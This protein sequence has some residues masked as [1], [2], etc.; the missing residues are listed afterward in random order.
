MVVWSF[1]DYLGIILRITLQCLL[2]ICSTSH[3]PHPQRWSS[4]VGHDLDAP[5]GRIAHRTAELHPQP[6]SRDQQ[7]FPAYFGVRFMMFH[8]RHLGRTQLHL[9]AI[10]LG[11][12]S[13][14]KNMDIGHH[15]RFGQIKIMYVCIFKTIQYILIHLYIYIYIY[16]HTTI[17]VFMIYAIP[18]MTSRFC[19]LRRR[20]HILFSFLKKKTSDSTWFILVRLG[21]SFFHCSFSRIS[22]PLWRLTKLPEV[23]S[24][25]RPHSLLHWEPARRPPISQTI[26]TIEPNRTEQAQ[27]YSTSTHSCTHCTHVLE[28][29]VIFFQEIKDHAPFWSWHFSQAMD[30]LASS[31][32]EL[33]RPAKS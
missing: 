22:T 15:G 10:A 14:L 3:S 8:V 26:Q 29:Y 32:S 2:Q 1:F 33:S 23:E 20:Q 24:L 17:F 9:I 31:G 16:I 25:R 11:V 19:D 7:S 30:H 21:S 6:D 27:E 13:K 12:A 28:K 4:L 5:H 18:C